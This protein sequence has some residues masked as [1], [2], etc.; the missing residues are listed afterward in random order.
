GSADVG[1]ELVDREAPDVKLVVDRGT[2]ELIHVE[3]PARRDEVREL[4]LDDVDPAVHEV[5][6][7]WLLANPDHA[8][9]F[10]LDEPVAQLVGRLDDPDREVV[11]LGTMEADELTEVDP[12]EEIRVGDDALAAERGQ[13]VPDRAGGPT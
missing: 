11:L 12:G 2:D 5:A 3:P 9:A 8:R 13:H 6:K 7:L 10:G 4:G 1:T